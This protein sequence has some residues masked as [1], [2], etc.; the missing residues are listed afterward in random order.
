MTGME[1]DPL[2]RV[3]TASTSTRLDLEQGARPASPCVALRR[4]TCTPSARAPPGPRCRTARPALLSPARG[5]AP[6]VCAAPQRP[7]SPRGLCGNRRPTGSGETAGSKIV[8]D[9]A[10]QEQFVPA[11]AGPNPHLLLPPESEG[12]APGPCAAN[13]PRGA[14]AAPGLDGKTLRFICDLSEEAPEVE[15]CTDRIPV[16][17]W[18]GGCCLCRRAV[19]VC[20]AAAGAQR[21]LPRAELHNHLL[22]RR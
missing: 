16:V 13:N 7:V 6:P 9:F 20:S 21:P 12:S 2:E 22:P 3:V 1:V 19:T 18:H 8:G 14:C 15:P 11:F 5:A 4:P 17:A 10:Q